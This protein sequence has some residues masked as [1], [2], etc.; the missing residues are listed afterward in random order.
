[1]MQTAGKHHCTASL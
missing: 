1:M